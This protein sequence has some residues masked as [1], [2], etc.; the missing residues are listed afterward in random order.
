M[1]PF[2]TSA[3]QLKAEGYTASQLK[4]LSYAATELKDAGYIISELQSGGYS[5]SE[6]VGA[7]YFASE[8][9]SAGYSASELKIAGYSASDIK[10]AGFSPQQM[11]D[12]GTGFDATALKDAGFTASDLFFDG[13]PSSGELKIAG[14]SASDIKLAGFSNAEVFSAGY[15]VSELQNAGYTASE[16]KAGGYSVNEAPTDITFSVSGLG[17]AETNEAGTVIGSLSA[18]DPDVDSKFTYTLVAGTDGADAD[19]GLVEIDGSKVRVKAGAVIDFENNP[20]LKIN[21]QVTDHGVPPL[22][23]TK[24]FTVNVLN[25]QEAGSLGPITSLEGYFQEGETL[26]AGLLSDPDRIT[27]TPTYIWYQGSTV[28]Q[29][30]TSNSYKVG[31]V[32]E[33]TYWVEASYVD[34]TGSTV[35]AASASQIVSKKDNGQ[36]TTVITSNGFFNE[37]VVLTA[38]PITNDPDGAAVNPIYSYQWYLDGNAISNATGSTYTTT[39][40]GF[41]TYRVALTYTDGQNYSTT[42][43]SANQVVTKID[44]GQ[45]NLSAITV[46]GPLTEGVTLTAGIVSS[47]ADG[48]GT[49]T[50]YQWL[51]N[52]NAISGATAVSYLV[53]ASGAGTY[54]VE[55]SY[56]DGQ[57]Y[58]FTLTSAPTVVTDNLPPTI[59]S[60][61]VQGTAVTL[62]FSEAVSALSVPLTAFA[63]ATV[64]S[65]NIATSRS[66]SSISLDQNDAK[67]IILTLSGNAPASN[68]SLRVSYTDPVGNQPIGVIQDLV[69]NDAVSFSNRY[70]D[71]FITASTTTLASQYQ[72]LVLTGSSNVNGIGNALN[73]SITG[74]SG[75]NTLDGGTGG[76]NLAGGLGNDTYIVDNI[77]DVVTEALNAGIDTVQSSITYTL[78]AN[79]ENLTLTGSGAV[80]GSGNS[81]NNTITGNSSSNSLVGGNG[82]DTLIGGAGVDLLTGIS[83]LDT[84][85]GKGTIDKLTGGTGNDLFI[86]GNNSG[87]F[88]GDSSTSTSGFSDYAWITDFSAGDKI[89]L[90]GAASNYILITNQVFSGVTGTALFL[91]D[92]TGLGS[93]SNG[94][95]GRDELVGLIQVARGV[96]LNLGSSTQFTYV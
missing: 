55:V 68:V 28:I 83:T 85:L 71:T 46:N 48:N 6:I 51:K 77:G 32:G 60:I 78:G 50:G 67:K 44:N 72:N 38:G 11:W 90:K 2:R 87:V 58:P 22:T 15:S 57:G 49:I 47:D 3:S 37:G 40:K 24:A 54:T 95:D 61:A 21:I 1:A 29:S 8:L 23:Y 64:N 75:N 27:S 5:S 53:P 34:G 79:A 89:Q 93:I 14:Y 74:N 18:T 7:G 20:I 66:V 56:D 39:A 17:I 63:V 65:N 88:Y 25:Q 16:L 10:L 86:L 92:G 96:T 62:T 4:D 94:F 76:D 91:N 19:N 36:G 33:G 70:A 81:L 30:G 13:G 80:N 82:S 9:F 52:G 45:G 73:N 31:S 35:K 12:S 84:T 41:G 59:I 42:I 43:N 26:T 69:G